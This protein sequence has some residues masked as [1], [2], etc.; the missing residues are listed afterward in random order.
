MVDVHQPT[1][2]DVV[3]DDPRQRVSGVRC[4]APAVHTCLPRIPCA[5]LTLEG[6]C[7]HAGVHQ[8][9]LETIVPKKEGDLLLVLRGEH[10]VSPY[11]VP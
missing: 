10:K 4:P 2:C 5:C 8:W 1:V 9:Q 11:A 7:G 6:R 3:V